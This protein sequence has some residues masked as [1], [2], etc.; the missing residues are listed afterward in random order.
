H[1]TSPRL[2]SLTHDLPSSFA[3]EGYPVH[4]AESESARFSLG[5]FFRRWIAD[6]S[7]LGEG[8]YELC[9]A[10]SDWLRGAACFARRSWLQSAQTSV[11]RVEH[12]VDTP[13]G[14]REHHYARAR[15]ILRS[16][17][18]PAAADWRVTAERAAQGRDTASRRA[19]LAH[20]LC[21]HCGRQHARDSGRDSVRADR[22]S[23]R[24]AS[25][26]RMGA[27]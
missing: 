26:H 13:G 15:F 2:I 24:P 8:T 16:V 21:N 12:P 1:D 7:L 5:R 20:P 17:S 22:S 23:R 19:R 6:R 10:S 18:G 4:L 27:R 9:W 11:V 14:S 25:C 3:L